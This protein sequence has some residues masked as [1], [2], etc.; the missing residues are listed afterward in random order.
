MDKETDMA[1]SAAV[2]LDEIDFRNK[3]EREAGVWIKQDDGSWR[4]NAEVRIP[5]LL[6]ASEILV[7]TAALLVSTPVILVLA[8]LIRWDTRG[9]VFFRHTRIGINGKPFMFIKLRSQYADNRQRFPEMCAYD[10][11]PES[12]PEVRL[13]V[14]DDPRVTRVGKWLRR[15]SLDELPNF[16]HVLTGDMTLVG[17]RPEMWEMFRYYQGEML[18]KFSVRPGITG[19]AQICGRGYLTFEETI[20]FDL[21]YVRNKSWR[22][23]MIILLRTIKQ[24]IAGDG[25]M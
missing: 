13:Q 5:V 21:E 12:L 6:R 18:Q 10:F 23:D 1:R 8:L 14:E 7:A 2:P 20:K 17:P 11:T 16:W 9:P 25:A 22:L 24:I 4:C 19:L 3:R 15:S